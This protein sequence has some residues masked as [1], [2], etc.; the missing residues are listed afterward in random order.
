[1]L[2]EPHR[3]LYKDEV[4]R[5]GELLG[6]PPEIVWRQPF[7]G[8]GLAI[9]VL[10]EVTTERLDVLREA[11]A[12]V[13]EEVRAAGYERQVW[14]AVAVLLPIRT[15]G[16]IGGFRPHAHGR[17]PRAGMSQDAKTAG[18]ARLTEDLLCMFSHP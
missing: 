18:W 1:M 16:V 15:G 2:D 9:R 12:V 17:A 5:L 13:Q 8:P 10:G 6:L 7:P 3:E 14:Q 4:R 11:D